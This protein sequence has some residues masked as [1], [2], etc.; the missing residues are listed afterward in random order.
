MIDISA[1]IKQLY[2]D[3]ADF[4]LRATGTGTN[5]TYR[6]YKKIAHMERNEAK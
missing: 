1:C 6:L 5:S 2:E 4:L 3:F